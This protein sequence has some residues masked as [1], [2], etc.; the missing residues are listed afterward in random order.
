MKTPVET[1]FFKQVDKAIEKGDEFT[2]YDC[3]LLPQDADAFQTMLN[4]CMYNKTKIDKQ[5]RS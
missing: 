4:L 5:V 1:D 3:S 2:V